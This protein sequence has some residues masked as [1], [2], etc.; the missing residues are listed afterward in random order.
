M[1]DARIHDAQIARNSLADAVY[2]RLRNQIVTGTLQPGERLLEPVLAET[3]GVSRTPIREALRRLEQA[4]LVRRNPRD[5]GRYV[6][7]L[8]PDEMREILGVR[9]VLEGY[10]ARL[11]AERAT[12]EDL[13]ALE[14]VHAQAQRTVD[15]GDTTKLVELNTQFHDG[16]NRASRAP[17]CVALIDE[18]RDRILQYRFAFLRN[19]RTR[20]DS[21]N[22]HGSILAA[23]R[24]RDPDRAEQLVRQ[25]IARIGEVLAQERERTK[26]Q[27]DDE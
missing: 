24:E 7:A 23:L 22:D 1:Q 2:E 4:E 8:P 14:A 15:D 25:H 12:T 18:L 9:A 20:R 11:A 3:L 26:G 19:E 6:H 21:F 10:A 13:D 17:H 5:L 16:I 27:T